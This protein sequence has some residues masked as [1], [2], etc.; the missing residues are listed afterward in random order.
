MLLCVLSWNCHNYSVCVCA[1][2]L[3]GRGGWVGAVCTYW[4]EW[5]LVVL[6]LWKLTCMHCV[7]LV[8]WTCKAVLGE[9]FLY[10]IYN[11]NFPP[12]HLRHTW[13]WWAKLSVTLT[14]FFPDGMNLLSDGHFQFSSGLRTILIHVVLQ[15]H[16]LQVCLR[17][18]SSHL[19]HVL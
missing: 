4:Y 9:I 15:E 17:R 18:N 16:R 5:S 10:D 13:S 6:S 14:L 7:H 11:I 2:A 3:T 1:A 8:L 19:E 12:L